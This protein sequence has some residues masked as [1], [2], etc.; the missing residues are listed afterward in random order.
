MSYSLSKVKFDLEKCDNTKNFEKSLRIINEILN[1]E[2][3]IDNI[4][5][6]N[7]LINQWSYITKLFD[8]CLNCLLH[9]KQCRREYKKMICPKDGNDLINF[10]NLYNK[11]VNRVI[12]IISKTK[13]NMIENNDI[14]VG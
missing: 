8:D 7:K 13:Y 12:K 5:Q 6:L 3:V 14:L 9:C 10:E 4:L 2:I 1:K 11:F